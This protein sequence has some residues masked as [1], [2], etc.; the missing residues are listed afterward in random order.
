VKRSAGHWVLLG[1]AGAAVAAFVVFGFFVAPAEEGFGTHEKLGL[2]PCTSMALFG[3]PCPGCG[4]TTSVALASR[5]RVADSFLTQPFG[6]V[7]ALLAALSIPWALWGHVTGR[8]LYAELVRLASKPV[9]V[10]LGLVVLGGWAY[11]LYVVLG[12]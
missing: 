2:P 12:A 1:L 3:V 8:D 5:G 11:K 6:L 7:V 9:L 4:V 10:V